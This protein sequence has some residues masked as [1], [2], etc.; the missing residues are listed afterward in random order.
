M[1]S[2]KHVAGAAALA[3]LMNLNGLD[4]LMGVVDEQANFSRL[5]TADIK[6]LSQ[7]RN[8][9]EL[10]DDEQSIDDLAA[11]TIDLGVLQPIIVCKNTTGGLEPYRLVAGERRLRAAILAD[12]AKVPAM[13]YGELSEELINRIQY[14]ENTHRKNLSMLNEAQVL[15]RDVEELGSIQAVC[16]KRNKPASWVSKRLQLLDLPEHT[17]LLLTENVTSDLETLN[18]LRQVEKISPEAGQEAAKKVREAVEKGEN[19]RKAAKAEKDK[20]KPPKAKAKPSPKPESL[21]EK[22]E[23]E[24]SRPR[25]SEGFEVG[26]SLEY[27]P[28][29]G[30]SAVAQVLA[31]LAGSA[32][33]D[34]IQE[35]SDNEPTTLALASEWLELYHTEGQTQIRPAVTLMESLRSGRFAAEGPSAA[36]LAAYVS[37]VSGSD[38]DIIAILE[39]V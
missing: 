33:L 15:A 4:D 25:K 30:S 36:A 9:D 23:E 18:M 5:D 38:F 24:F 2:E 26:A 21:K 32:L 14:S 19:V 12:L 1:K 20:V 16:Q 28:N 10:E 17:R 7:Q 35:F 34:V 6:I 8:K 27:D 39:A 13:V 37:G 29:E 22:E 31:Q 11:D 3:D